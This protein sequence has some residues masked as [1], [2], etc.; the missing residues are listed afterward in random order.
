V[1]LRPCEG[2]PFVNPKSEEV[3][4]PSLQPS[5]RSDAQP[6]T[7]QPFDTDW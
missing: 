7:Q 1:D 2:S 5:A 6:E 4:A 3:E